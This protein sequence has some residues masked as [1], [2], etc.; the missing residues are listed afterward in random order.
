MKC[1]HCGGNIIRTYA[2]FGKDNEKLVCLQCSRD[3]GHKCD[4]DCDRI[5]RGSKGQYKPR[6]E[7]TAR[8]V[9]NEALKRI[10]EGRPFLSF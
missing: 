9:A 3:V 7:I 10:G 8:D 1:N 6:G 5:K 4:D 2:G